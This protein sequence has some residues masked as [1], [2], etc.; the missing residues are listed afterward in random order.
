METYR[1]SEDGI[2]KCR[3]IDFVISIKFQYDYMN[4]LFALKFLKGLAIYVIR[5]SLA[6]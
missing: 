5:Y 6:Y 1:L 2:W 3:N 4:I